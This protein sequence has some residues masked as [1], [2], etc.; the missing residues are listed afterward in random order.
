MSA[1]INGREI[2]AVVFDVD[3]TL[4]PQERVEAIFQNVRT[5][6]AIRLL[7]F[8]G[9]VNPSEE[10]IIK[11]RRAYMKRAESGGSFSKAFEYYGGT[12]QEFRQVVE[13][14]DRSK[15]L[16]PS[17]ELQKMITNIR[18]LVSIG[19]FTSAT[20]EVNSNTCAKIL[21]A[22][23]RNLFDTVLCCDTTG[24]DCE[25]PQLEA[26][27]LVVSNLNTKLERTAMIGDVSGADLVPAAYLGM[28]TIQVERN[29]HPKADVYLSNVLDL[30][31]LLV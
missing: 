3:G 1:I 15:F 31:H 5:Q 11:M 25:K 22:N 20:E 27:R 18:A 17:A 21:G 19:L 2:D 28:L 8:Q 23:W 14:T 9:I 10:E 7:G 4:Y 29:D 26:F 13:S 6:I 16:Q 12:K 24:A 30:E